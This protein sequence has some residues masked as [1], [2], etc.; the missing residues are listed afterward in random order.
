MNPIYCGEYVNNKYEIKDC[1]EGKQFR[2][3]PDQHLH[4]ERPEWAIVS[5]ETFDRAQLLL[6]ER[7]K[8][9]D[10]APTFRDGRHSEKHLF[11]TLIKCEHCGRSFFQK[12][13]TYVNTRYYWKCQTNDQFTA[14]K[15]DNRVT[16]TEGDL[17]NEIRQY[18]ASLIIDKEQFIQSVLTELEKNQEKPKKIVSKA[19]LQ[20]RK[21]Q[22]QS[23]KEKYQ[24]MYAADVMSMQELKEKMTYINKEIDDLNEQLDQVNVSDTI[25]KISIEEVRI[26]TEE[27]EDFL[28]LEN[29]TNGD[30]RKII[31][32]IVVN[33]EGEIKIYLRN[34]S[35]F[36]V[37]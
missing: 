21:K 27:I 6:D 1:L 2:I 22:L 10:S 11:S 16:I 8:Q 13:Y 29:V 26:Y 15:C 4:H 17:L 5:R 9:Y 14:E 7:R 35:D 12:H 33:R 3:P 28:A 31:S 37:A 36:M 18:L 30:L 32:R 20:K 19:Y 23:K 24:E 25:E 34:F